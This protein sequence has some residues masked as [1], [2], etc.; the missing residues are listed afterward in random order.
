MTWLHPGFLVAGAV[1]ALAVVALH[2]IMHRLPPVTHFPTARFVPPGTARAIRRAL[3]P[4]DLLLLALRAAMVLLAG[5][6]LARPVVSPDRRAIARVVVLDRSRAVESIDVARDSVRALI[7]AADVLVIFDSAA[8]VVSAPLDSIGVIERT[9]ARGNL[10]AALVAA[11]HASALLSDLADSIEIALV[12]PALAEEMDAA[13]RSVRAAWPG[14]IRVVRVAGDTTAE[15]SRGGRERTVVASPDDPVAAGI[16]L[17]GWH[18]EA[19]RVRLVRRTPV[20]DDSAWAHGGGVLVHWPAAPEGAQGPGS[21]SIGA[22]ITEGAVVVAGFARRAQSGMDDAAPVAW[23][24]DGRPAAV[25]RSSG[26][27][28]IREV[29]IEVPRRGDLVLRPSFRRLLHALT[30]PCHGVSDS[31]PLPDGAM[32][33]LAGEG[34]LAHASALPGASRRSTLAPWLLLGALALA[35]L[36]PLARRR[37]SV[38]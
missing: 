35:L 25:Q 19:Q 31:R 13:T 27:G 22:V 10:S 34:T 33:L 30:R 5:A 21:D 36:E 8:R 17:W 26:A 16:A 12:T 6:A 4:D 14:R 29:A 20:P 11:I 3:R 23:W 28:C 32:A 18:S 2:L 15:G 7:S 38:E 24:A 37:R 1:A 9:G